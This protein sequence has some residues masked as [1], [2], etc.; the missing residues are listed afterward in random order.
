MLHWR[1]ERLSNCGK[2][3]GFQGYCPSSGKPLLLCS[4]CSPSRLTTDGTAHYPGHRLSAISWRLQA[5]TW[6]RFPYPLV[7]GGYSRLPSGSRF[8]C[9]DSPAAVHTLL[10]LNASSQEPSHA[11]QFCSVWHS[12]T[13]LDSSPLIVRRIGHV[14]QRT[15]YPAVHDSYGYQHCPRVL[16]LC[17]MC[18]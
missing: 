4:L 7:R 8:L 16:A 18:R 10:D 1:Y 15:N 6:L 14:Q 2:Q 5:V 9:D 3:A 13:V 17:L 11:G 12:T